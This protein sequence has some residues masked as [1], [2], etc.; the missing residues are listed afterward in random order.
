MQGP[1]H[2]LKAVLCSLQELQLPLRWSKR[3]NVPNA[4]WNVMQEK[5]QK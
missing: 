3:P 2:L 5:A 1:A 4:N